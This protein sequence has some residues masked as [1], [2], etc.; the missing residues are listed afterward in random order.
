MYQNIISTCHNIEYI[1]KKCYII[2]HTVFQI[3]SGFYIH[4]HS[5]QL[6]PKY[7]VTPHPVPALWDNVE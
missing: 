1:N 3:Q 4:Q 7:T 6:L 2:F 5:E